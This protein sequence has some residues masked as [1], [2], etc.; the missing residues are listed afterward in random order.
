MSDSHPGPGGL[1][2]FVS[3][4]THYLKSHEGNRTRFIPTL[5]TWVKSVPRTSTGRP[6]TLPLSGTGILPVLG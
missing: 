3:G 2:P 4:T 6:I 5:D 1:V